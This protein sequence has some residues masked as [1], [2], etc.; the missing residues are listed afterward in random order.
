MTR[1]DTLEARWSYLQASLP[2]FHN[3]Q[4][5]HR[6]FLTSTII[7]MSAVASS[8]SLRCIEATNGWPPSDVASMK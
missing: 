8:I 6:S 2:H 3:H 7:S 1:T 5:V 4:Y